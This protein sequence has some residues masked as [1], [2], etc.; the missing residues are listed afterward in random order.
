[1]RSKSDLHRI[2][3]TLVILLL[4]ACGPAETRETQEPAGSR[5]ARQQSDAA[6]ADTEAAHSLSATFRAAAQRALPAVVYLEVERPMEAARRGQGPGG[7][8]NP[9]EFFFGPQGPQGPQGE[10]PP[11]QGSGSGFIIDGEGHVITNNH[12]V[13]DA[14]WVLVRLTDGREFRAEVVGSDPASDVAVLKIEPKNG[15]T[16]PTVEIGSSDPLQVGD[17]VLA[18]GSPF[19]LESTVTA[20]I[21]S[22]KRRQITGRQSALEAFLQTDAAINPG[23]SGGPLVDLDGRVVGINSAILGGPAFVGYGFAIPIDLAKKVV[24]DILEFGEVRRPQ[25]GVTISDVNAVDAEAYGLSE[26]R[27]ADIGTIVPAGP[28][29]EA[30]LQIGDVILAVDDD[31]IADAADLTT[32]LAEHQPGDEVTLTIFRDGERRQVEVELG[33]FAAEAPERERERAAQASVERLGF[34]V[35][36]LT[37]P[38]AERLGVERAD[39]LVITEVSPFGAAASAGVAAGQVL[40]RINGQEV[41]TPADVDRI[42]EGV[43]PGDVVSLRLIVPELG[44]TILNYRVR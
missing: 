10:L 1:M 26:V 44:E 27:G 23:N 8:V 28:A 40:L 37:P 42:A 14:S 34:S 41:E 11:Q 18:L 38:L 2:L 20:G 30:G 16:L 17:W 35:E 24:S 22:A 7:P 39:G 33:R 4:A 19:E 43:E 3:A 21:I 31:E 25:L 15:D 12:V 13:A 9:F 5:L 6:P 29:E 32:T 36:P